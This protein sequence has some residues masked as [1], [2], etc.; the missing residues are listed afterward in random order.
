MRGQWARDYYS[1]RD[2]ETLNSGLSDALV[3]LKYMMPRRRPRQPAARTY[4]VGSC[5]F[6]STY[7][8]VKWDGEVVSQLI[9]TTTAL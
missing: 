9:D 7:R 6:S 2:P 5:I 1:A 4:L 8:T 3:A